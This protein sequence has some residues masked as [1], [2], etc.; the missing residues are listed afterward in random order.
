MALRLIHSARTTGDEQSVPQPVN[1]LKLGLIAAVLFFVIKLPMCFVTNNP[2]ELRDFDHFAK[3]ASGEYAYRDFVFIYGPLAPIVYGTA[4]KVL[5]KRLISVRV[6]TLAIWS[7]GAAFAAALLSLYFS[8]ITSCVWGVLFATGLLGYPSYSHNHILAAVGALA[9]VYYLIRYIEKEELS[10][11]LGSFA[12]L[13]VVVFTRPILTGYGSAAVW[14]AIVFFH[15]PDFAR[16]RALVV[17]AAGLALLFGFFT[18]IYGKGVVWAFF[19]RPW[20][21]LPSKGYPNLHYLIPHLSNGMGPAL[22]KQIWAALETGTFYLHFFVWPTLVFTL[23]Y[24]LPR[25]PTFRAAAICS[26]FALAGSLD[27]LHYGFSDPVSEQAMWVRG[28]YFFGLTGCSLFLVLAPAAVGTNRPLKRSAAKAVLFV[29]A[30][31]S[32]LPY[33]LGVDHLDRFKFNQYEFPALTGIL[34]HTDRRYVFEAI[35]F[36]NENCQPGDTVVVPQYDP[37][38][39]RLL[40]CPELFGNDPYIFTRWTGYRLVAGETP[41]S[42]EG[43]VTNGDLITNYLRKFNPRFFLVQGNPEFTQV[44]SSP[45]WQ[46]RQFGEGA[47]GRKVCFRP[48]SE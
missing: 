3:S 26:A 2:E 20:A 10:S 38:L 19:P 40:R 18:L 9:G 7:V 35:K 11:L 47:N 31:W 30:L 14:F 4:L 16:F 15:K 13:A 5:P 43:G 32:Y 21:V 24:I 45:G 34:T 42:P 12:A 29:V 1:R 6:F 37:G 28:Q 8:S 44:C 27:L 23:A 36:I 46:V 41:Y 22:P 48:P 33:A 39:G 17:F 25:H